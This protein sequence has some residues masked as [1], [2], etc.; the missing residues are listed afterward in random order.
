MIS[1]DAFL[2]RFLR[3]SKYSLTRATKELQ[4]HLTNR[5]KYADYFGSF[6][7]NQS[8][9]AA[10]LD[11]NFI[12]VTPKTDSDG[13]RVVFARPGLLN[14]DEFSNI[15]F[16]RSIFAMAEIVANMEEVQIVG[17]KLIID[18]SNTTMKTFGQL[19]AKNYRDMGELFRS[20][21]FRMKIGYIVNAPKFAAHVVNFL[22]GFCKPKVKN[23]LRFLIGPDELKQHIDG[24]VLPQEYGGIVSIEDCR[25]Y[26]KDLLQEMREKLLQFSEI[27]AEFEDSFGERAGGSGEL[28]FGAIGS[29]RKLELD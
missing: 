27:E 19:S 11:A 8:R 12:L 26:L 4:A 25:V 14:F 10:I 21:W 3:V 1:D 17:L 5:K 15:D 7:V 6:D 2:V 9:L 24:N 28:E 22:V 29:F 16:M 13:C 20:S 23:R 18:L